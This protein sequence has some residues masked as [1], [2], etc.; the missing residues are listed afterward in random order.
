MPL[1]TNIKNQIKARLDA[2]KT[3][4]KLGEVIVDDF[5]LGIFERDFSAFPAAILTTPTI[6][7]EYFTSGENMRTHV[8]EIVVIMRGENITT[9]TQVEE[10]A[11]AILDEFDKNDT[12][13]GTAIQV[14]PATTAPEAVVS[15]GKSFIAFSVVVR[16]KG[17][18]TITV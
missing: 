10:L 5:K 15:R 3:A 4:G 8:F 7:G 1:V 16:A 17:L 6:E 9:A 18:K 14:E 12:L 2:L 13:A 11:E